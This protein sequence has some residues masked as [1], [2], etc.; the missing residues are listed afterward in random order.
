MDELK[1]KKQLKKNNNIEACLFYESFGFKYDNRPRDCWNCFDPQ[2]A[3]MTCMLLD[4]TTL[5]LKDI[6]NLMDRKITLRD[7]IIKT[8]CE[9]CVI[10]Q[11]KYRKSI[12]KRKNNLS[13]P[14]WRQRR[15]K[16][17]KIQKG[18]III[19]FLKIYLIF[20]YIRISYITTFFSSSF[21]FTKFSSIITIF[22]I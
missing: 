1:L 22:I 14:S 5:T 11:C 8:C 10:S 7:D 20:R 15:K 18:I 2:D 19:F 9:K 16:K 13:S 3:N 17:K 12:K 4:L 6:Y 21:F